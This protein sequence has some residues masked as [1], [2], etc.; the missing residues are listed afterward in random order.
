[1]K[2]QSSIYL[3]AIYLKSHC[4]S[5]IHNLKKR[6]RANNPMQRISELRNI[7]GWKIKTVKD[8]LILLV[9]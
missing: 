5:Y 7:H 1:M 8:G 4:K 2:K 9:F 3:T 6:T